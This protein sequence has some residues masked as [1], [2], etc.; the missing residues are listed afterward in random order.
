MEQ[1]IDKL[2]G[3][4]EKHRVE[5]ARNYLVSTINGDVLEHD[6]EEDHLVSLIDAEKVLLK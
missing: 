5:R 3:K 2:K 1:N 6:F 4:I